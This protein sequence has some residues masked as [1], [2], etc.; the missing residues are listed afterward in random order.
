MSQV[1]GQN[2]APEKGQNGNNLTDGEFKTLVIRMLNEFKGRVEKF[3]A[4]T[5]REKT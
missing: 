1:K 3:R 4:L 2:K 5:K